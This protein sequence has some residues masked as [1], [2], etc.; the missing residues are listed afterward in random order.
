VKIVVANQ[1]RGVG[2]TCKMSAASRRRNRKR[3]ER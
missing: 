2:Y 1:K 3:R